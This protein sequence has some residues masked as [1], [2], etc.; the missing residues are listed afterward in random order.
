MLFAMTTF[1][2]CTD[3][4]NITGKK[5]TENPAL[6]TIVDEVFFLHQEKYHGK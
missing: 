6:E 1:K 5:L 4:Q 2:L 3:K